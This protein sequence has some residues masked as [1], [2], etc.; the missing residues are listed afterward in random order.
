[1]AF[2]IY[3]SYLKNR[4]QCVIMNNLTIQIART[5]PSSILYYILNNKLK[6]LQSYKLANNSTSFIHNC[7][8]IIF[9]GNY[10]LKGAA[11]NLIQINTGGYF[12]FDFYRILKE[13]K[14]NIPNG[15]YL[16]HHI[17]VYLYMLLKANEH[18]WPIV[19]FFSEIS[20]I[21]NAFVYYYIQKDKLIGKNYKSLNTK[22]VKKLQ[23]WFYGFFRIFVIGYYGLCEYNNKKDPPTSVY[24]TSVLYFFGL[25]W[26]G[27][28]VK[29]NLSQ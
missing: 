15:M 17:A 7:L 18:Y 3:I 8:A 16:Y 9:C 2:K 26:V 25:I 24:M 1:M 28:I 6:K 5:I 12:I 22:Y 13:D 29:Q 20:N 14:Y 21:P 23:M 11:S 27:F 19:L 4:R 10:L